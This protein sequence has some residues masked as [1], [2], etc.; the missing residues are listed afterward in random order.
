MEL[1]KEVF[2]FMTYASV[3]VIGLLVVFSLGIIIWAKSEQLIE[4]W[5]YRKVTIEER[6]ENLI[7]SLEDINITSEAVN[8][9]R[10]NNIFKL[11]D[12]FSYE[13]LKTFRNPIEIKHPV[14]GRRKLCVNSKTFLGWTGTGAKFQRMSSIA[15]S[16]V[17]DFSDVYCLISDDNEQ[18]FRLISIEGFLKAYL[19]NFDICVNSFEPPPWNWDYS[20][21]SELDRNITYK[22]PKAHSQMELIG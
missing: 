21:S 14:H 4:W 13:E 9:I 22:Y 19:T 16:S 15:L 6:S 18:Q 1:L 2:Y 10:A 12:P 3:A 17:V 20:I 11:H 5:K 8:Y 7:L